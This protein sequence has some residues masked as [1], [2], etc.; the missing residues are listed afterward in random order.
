[1]CFFVF[2]L[3]PFNLFVFNKILMVKKKAE[4][5]S[6][7]QIGTNTMRL[8]MKWRISLYKL[9]FDCFRWFARFYFYS[10]RASPNAL[11]LKSVNGF[12]WQVFFFFLILK[13]TTESNSSFLLLWDILLGQ[14]RANVKWKVCVITSK[15]P[16][17]GVC[18]YK[19]SAEVW[20][21]V[22]HLSR[23]KIVWD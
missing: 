7:D 1:M 14:M 2:F 23:G 5:V 9:L 12:F 18:G 20:N 17:F 21:P 16:K 13:I 4:C 10:T 3:S 22:L 6:I 15:C 8:S 11:V 19:Q